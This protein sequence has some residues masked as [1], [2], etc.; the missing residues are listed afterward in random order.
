MLKK[1]ISIL[2]CFILSFVF[3]GCSQVKPEDS[4][5]GYFEALKK[6]DIQAA[7]SFM[8]NQN[9]AFVGDAEQEKILNL[10]FSNLNYE[11]ISS[12]IDED[13]A[14]VKLK[15]TACDLATVT[16]NMI[17]DLMGQLI[18]M[19]LSGEQDLEAKSAQLREEYFTKALNDPQTPLITSEIDINLVMDS[20]SKKWLIVGDDNLA[21]AITGNFVTAMKKFSEGF[22]K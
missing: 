14:V 13:K 15:V 4:I 20:S 10:I 8:Q 1:R 21:N 7:Q 11:V 19:A 9:E 5:K 3:V 22:S 6:Q 2:L 17:K 16:G 12:T 18:S